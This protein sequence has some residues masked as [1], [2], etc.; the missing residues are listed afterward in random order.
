MEILVQKRTESL[1][2]AQLSLLVAYE[3]SQVI[4]DNLI[5]TNRKL[6]DQ[7]DQLRE[8][9]EAN[10]EI[11]GITVH[12]LKNPLGGIIGLAE[13]VLEDAREKP[14]QAFDSVEDNIPTLKEEAERMLQII[15]SLLD[16]HR[17]NEDVVLSKENAFWETSSLPYYAGIQNRPVRRV[18]SFTVV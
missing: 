4:N 16:K 10:K 17:Q 5:T 14:S 3:E 18:L 13:I 12:D 15:K 1:L 9:L 2:E 6:E 7:S 8:S 11:L